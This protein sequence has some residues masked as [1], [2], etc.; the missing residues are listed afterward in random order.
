MLSYNLVPI[1]THREQ[2]ADVALGASYLMMA[3]LFREK[4][5][6]LDKNCASLLKPMLNPNISF[7]SHG[8]VKRHKIQSTTHQ[9]KLKQND[10]IFMLL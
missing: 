8:K 1:E 4:E 5:D 2:N 6:D 9:I 7:A 3:I 10:D